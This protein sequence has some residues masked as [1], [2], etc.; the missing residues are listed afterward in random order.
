MR[1][2]AGNP[3]ISP[4]IDKRLFLPTPSFTPAE[5]ETEQEEIADN[6][7]ALDSASRCTSLSTGGRR[8]GAVL[9]ERPLED[10]PVGKV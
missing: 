8:L 6:V 2:T 3:E 1:M 4:C 10:S 7:G 5:S 9:P